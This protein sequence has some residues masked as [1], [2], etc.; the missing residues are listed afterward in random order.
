[1][2]T[3]ANHQADTPVTHPVAHPVTTLTTAR[4][5]RNGGQTSAARETTVRAFPPDISV[6][7]PYTAWRTA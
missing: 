4:F 2:M 6:P 1:M 3:A 5:R 7:A